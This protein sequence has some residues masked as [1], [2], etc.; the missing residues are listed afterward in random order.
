MCKKIVSV[1]FVLSIS[2]Y[3]ILEVSTSLEAHN[4]LRQHWFPEQHDTF[5]ASLHSNDST[6]PDEASSSPLLEDETQKRLPDCLIIGFSKCGTTALR[7]FLTL[8]PD[9]VSPL[10]EIRYFTSHYEENLEWYKNQ[11]PLSTA[12]Q[13]TVE[14]SA[15]YISTSESLERIRQMNASVKLVVMVRDPITRLQSEYARSVS[16]N[17]PRA[18]SFRTWCGGTAQSPSVL[19]LVDYATP[20]EQV[21]SLFP[22]QQVLVLS[23]ELLEEKPLDILKEVYGFLGLKNTFEKTDL[24]FN[25]EKGFFCFNTS[26]PK[27]PKAKGSIVLNEKTGCLGSHKGRAHPEIG[28]RFFKELVDFIRPHNQRLFSLI[29]RKFNWPN[30]KGV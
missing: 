3:I 13:I 1:L 29:G 6:P 20:L 17:S 15:G 4:I 30:F 5:L 27:Y 16:K 7:G 18:P 10:R 11:M 9:I 8:H 21:F 25:E 14:K 2:I 23:E 22:R 12:A 24:V 28:D 19:R 26:S